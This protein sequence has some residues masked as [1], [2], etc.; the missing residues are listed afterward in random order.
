VTDPAIRTYELAFKDGGVARIDIPETW[1]ITFG[2]VA[3]AKGVVE[4]AGFAFRAWQTEGKQRL[5]FTRVESFRDVSLPMQVKAVRRFGSPE[6]E[7]FLDD[8]SWTG[9]KAALVE[10]GWKSIDDVLSTDPEEN[11]IAQ[12][13][14][15]DTF[16]GWRPP[17]AKTIVKRPR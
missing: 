7:W 15:E 13:D 11:A 14:D 5:L 10:H 17:R 2:P 9:K 3:G 1:K 12:V 6:T 4:G 16:S 8:G